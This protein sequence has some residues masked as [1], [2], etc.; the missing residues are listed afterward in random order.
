MKQ[1]RKLL[2]ALLASPFLYS[3]GEAGVGFDVAAELPIDIG[4]MEIP[5]QGAGAEV[6]IDAESISFSYSLSDV[7]GFD[8]ALDELN[9]AGAEVFLIGIA[10]EFSGV[11]DATDTYDEKVEI[12]SIRMEFTGISDVIEIAFPGGDLDNISKTD[13]IISDDLKEEITNRLESG[14]D[15]GVDFIFDIGTITTPINNEILDF[16]IK[17]YFDAAIRVRDIAN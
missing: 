16:D 1:I 6:D 10:Y 7:D 11:N 13:M 8:D 4:T 17:V 2:F 15:L 14:Q 12:Q 3:C 9:S 5:L